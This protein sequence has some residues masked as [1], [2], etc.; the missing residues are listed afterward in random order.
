MELTSAE[1]KLLNHLAHKIFHDTLEKARAIAGEH[2]GACLTQAP[3]LRVEDPLLWQCVQGHVWGASISTIE[4]T[5]HWC[6]YC[7]KGQKIRPKEQMT[8]ISTEYL[9]HM[10]KEGFGLLVDDGDLLAR[11]DLVHGTCMDCCTQLL[12]MQKQWESLEECPSCLRKI[13]SFKALIRE[14]SD[15]N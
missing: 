4:K 3:P 11:T 13:E 15:V 1:K 8:V 7:D 5:G 10:S 9:Q 6:P 12:L 14:T 2:G